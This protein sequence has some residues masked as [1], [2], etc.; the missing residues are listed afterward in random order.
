[1]SFQISI[2]KHQWIRGLVGVVVQTRNL[3]PLTLRVK[4][5]SFLTFDS[6]DRKAVE[7]RFNVM[8]VV[9]ILPS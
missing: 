6:G 9:L 2:D 5:Q 4:I 1:M 3:N 8:F 7:Q